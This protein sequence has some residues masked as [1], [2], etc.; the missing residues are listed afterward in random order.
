[1]TK[2]PRFLAACLFTFILWFLTGW[3]AGAM[4]FIDDWKANLFFFLF[5]EGFALVGALLFTGA[6]ADNFFYEVIETDPNDN[7]PSFRAM[8]RTYLQ[9]YGALVL[10]GLMAGCMVMVI[11]DLLLTALFALLMLALSWR[12]LKH[13]RSRVLNQRAAAEAARRIRQF[14]ELPRLRL[15]GSGE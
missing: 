15:P 8:P 9:L 6:C 12:S 13:I 5:R 4:T 7:P 2:Y 14:Q 1:M 3:G 10:P 11:L